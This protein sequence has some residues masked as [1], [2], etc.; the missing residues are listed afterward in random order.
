MSPT[1]SAIHGKSS[2]ELICVYTHVYTY[3]HFPNFFVHLL[4]RFLY[5]CDLGQ[6]VAQFAEFKLPSRV[7]GGF[8]WRHLF[9]C[10][11]LDDGT[12]TNEKSE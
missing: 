1:L 4:G 9:A 6:F 3:V 11:L 2:E 7:S 8:L 10:R 12:Q 5:T